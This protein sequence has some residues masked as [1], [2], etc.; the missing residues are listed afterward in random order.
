MDLNSKFSGFLSV[1][2]KN[3][4]KAYF[5][6]GFTY[7]SSDLWPVCCKFIQ[8]S[9]DLREI[10]FIFMFWG[11]CHRS[12]R[13]D[14]VETLET[15]FFMALKKFLNLHNYLWIYKKRQN[16]Q[17]QDSKWIWNQRPDSWYWH[18]HLPSYVMS[19]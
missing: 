9:R 8:F 18:A 1:T 7:K 13:E 10:S 14:V 17:C 16:C 15:N 4:V 11:R 6:Y 19:N 12:R 2:E 5:K 3:G